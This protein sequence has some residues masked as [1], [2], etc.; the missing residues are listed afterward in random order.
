[1]VLIVNCNKNKNSNNK[2]QCS[3]EGKLWVT[4][5]ERERERVGTTANEQNNEKWKA[6]RI[7]K[8]KTYAALSNTICNS[9]KFV[10]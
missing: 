6:Q 4:E 10:S 5:R 7:K 1:M 8:R 9:G 2:Y 3:C